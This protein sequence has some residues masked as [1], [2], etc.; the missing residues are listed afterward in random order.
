MAKYIRSL[1]ESDSG[2]KYDGTIVGRLAGVEVVFLIDSGADVN[3]IGAD[4]FDLLMSNCETKQ[5]LFCL[6]KGSDVPLKAYA[7]LED[8]RVKATFVTD[9]VISEDRPHLLE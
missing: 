7:T 6:E 4:T 5:S 9:L 2:G 3:T 8:I 1:R